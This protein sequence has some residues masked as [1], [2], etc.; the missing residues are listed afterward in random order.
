MGN[1]GN[2]GTVTAVAAPLLLDLFN[3]AV[4]GLSTV[5]NM[6]S[7]MMKGITCPLSHILLVYLSWLQVSQAFCYTLPLHVKGS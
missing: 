2:S 4:Y 7:I 5:I 3:V 1:S 6:L